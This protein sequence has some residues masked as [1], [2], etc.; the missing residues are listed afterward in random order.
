MCR[1]HRIPAD[2]KNA[3]A[4]GDLSA[5]LAFVFSNFTFHKLWFPLACL[6]LS[7]NSIKVFGNEMTRTDPPIKAE[8]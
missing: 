6:Q 8:G 3:T 2:I 7:R 4:N 1:R 5:F